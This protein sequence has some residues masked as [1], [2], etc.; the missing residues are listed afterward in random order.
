MKCSSLDCEAEATGWIGKKKFCSECFLFI[1]KSQIRKHRRIMI[2][3]KKGEK[4]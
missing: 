1:T 4:I 2:N 3:N